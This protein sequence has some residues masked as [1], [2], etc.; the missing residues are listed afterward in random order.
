[1]PPKDEHLKMLRRRH[2]PQKDTVRCE[3]GVFYSF[4]L[5]WFIAIS[6]VLAFLMSHIRRRVRESDR[7]MQALTLICPLK[8]RSFESSRQGTPSSP[9]APF[10][11]R[12]APLR[13]ARRFLLAGTRHPLRCAGSSG[14]PSL[15][16]SP[17]PNSAPPCRSTFSFS[18]SPCRSVSCS[19]RYERAPSRS[20]P[21][22]LFHFLPRS[23]ERLSPFLSNIPA[24]RSSLRLMFKLSLS[25][26]HALS[27]PSF[28]F[29]LS[30]AR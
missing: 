24:S 22:S 20:L 23:L 1:M 19:L 13:P 21:L 30:L 9:A 25:L 15:S 2:Y 11:S 3:D 4:P 5:L 10:L 28:S 17:S 26:V 14:F 18:F 8:L 29:S 27:F 16:L 6:T 7:T 12:H